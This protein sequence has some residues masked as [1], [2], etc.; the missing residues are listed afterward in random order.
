VSVREVVAASRRFVAAAPAIPVDTGDQLQLANSRIIVALADDLAEARA[1]LEAPSG[2][3]T[4]CQDGRSAKP[5]PVK[6]AFS[7]LGFVESPCWECRK[8][9]FLTRTK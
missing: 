5:R 8:A 3:R 9:A 6:C 4:N 1:L 2:Q 7:G